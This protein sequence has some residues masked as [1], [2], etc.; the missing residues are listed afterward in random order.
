VNSLMILAADDEATDLWL[1]TQ[2]LKAEKWATKLV[3]A[4]DGEEAVEYLL[5]RGDYADREKYPVPDLLLLDLKMPRMSGTE[6]LQWVRKSSEYCS[7][8]VVILSGSVIQ[9]DIEQ[10]YRQGANAFFTKP[11]GFEE[12]KRLV[13][14][15]VGFWSDAQRPKAPFPSWGPMAEETGIGR[16]D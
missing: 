16:R 2:A 8:P 13:H 14:Y 10:A 5:G 15:I 1:L 11:S 4:H 3:T 9:E 7:L 12:L 6:V